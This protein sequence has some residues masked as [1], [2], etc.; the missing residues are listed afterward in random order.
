MRSKLLFFLIFFALLAP[1]VAFSATLDE[2]KERGFVRVGFGNEIP[3][4]YLDEQGR[5]T[6]EAPEVARAVFKRLGINKIEGVMTEFGALIPGLKAGRFD[7][8]A[9]GMYI[10]PRRCRQVAFSEPSYKIGEA[11][12]VQK[13]NPH[14]IHSYDDLAQNE[15][16]RLGVMAGAV[17]LGYARKKG[18]GLS[19]LSV[20]SDIPTGISEL[21][22]GRI[23]AYAG[24]ALTIERAARQNEGIERAQPFKPLSIDG[25]RVDGYGAFGFKKSDKELRAAFD[26]ELAKFLGTKEHLELVR[27]FGFTKAELPDKSRQELC[28][29]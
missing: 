18:I 29:R 24:T 10:M 20:S 13:G 15:D 2:I 14:K 1:L 26:R 8:I 25:K 17:E 12:A 21:K 22:S 9:A 27:P 28:D 5:L 23:A 7:V 19:R 4:G 3:Y 16:L 11:L 6:G